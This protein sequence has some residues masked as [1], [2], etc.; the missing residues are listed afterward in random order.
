MKEIIKKD[1][2]KIL[3]IRNDKIGDF[4]AMEYW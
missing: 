1:V 2:K 3:L 4:V